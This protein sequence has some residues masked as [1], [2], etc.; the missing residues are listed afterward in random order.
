M[1]AEDVVE[2]M[3]PEKSQGLLFTATGKEIC[4]DEFEVNRCAFVQEGWCT[5]ASTQTMQ[6]IHKVVIITET[7]TEVNHESIPA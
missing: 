6:F 3:E 5:Y 7:E 4:D 2:E 1:T